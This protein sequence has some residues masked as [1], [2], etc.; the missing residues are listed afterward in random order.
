MPRTPSPGGEGDG[1]NELGGCTESDGGPPEGDKLWGGGGVKPLVTVRSPALVKLGWEGAEALVRLPP[2]E[3][4]VEL[5]Y[6][7]SDVRRGEDVGGRMELLPYD[8]KLDWR[9]LSAS[10]VV[11]AIEVDEVVEVPL[12]LGEAVLGEVVLG[13]T[14]LSLGGCETGLT[15]GLTL[16]VWSLSPLWSRH[17]QSLPFGLNLL[18]YLTGVSAAYL[19]VF[20]FFQL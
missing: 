11:A 19:C 7:C 1:V 14:G 13:G 12:L 9:V 5:P 17:S 18:P 16:R 10:C 4:V 2:V 3:A 20:C 15:P 8:V 6:C